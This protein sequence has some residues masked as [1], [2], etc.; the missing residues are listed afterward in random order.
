M[1]VQPKQVIASMMADDE[2]PD[3]LY[4]I[5][6]VLATIRDEE[7]PQLPEIARRLHHLSYLVNAQA[8]ID[9][10]VSYDHLSCAPWEDLTHPTDDTWDGVHIFQAGGNMGGDLDANGD[11]VIDGAWYVADRSDRTGH[12]GIHYVASGPHWS[13]EEAADVA[14]RHYIRTRAPALAA[15]AGRERDLGPAS[16]EPYIVFRKREERLVEVARAVLQEADFQGWDSPIR[17]LRAVFET[18]RQ[19]VDLYE[20]ETPQGP[21]IIHASEEG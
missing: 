1:S 4:R 11:P 20:H 16:P 8:R 7:Q 10:G 13:V 9:Q 21:A 6:R 2:T 5:L 18:L 3:W 12:D 17:N 14:L 15:K 19:V